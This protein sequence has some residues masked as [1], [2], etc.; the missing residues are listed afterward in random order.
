ME[1]DLRSLVLDVYDTQLG[2]WTPEHGELEI[3]EDWDFLIP[4]D[5]FVT[6]TVK[7]PASIGWRGCLGAA[8][9]LIVV[10]WACGPRRR[11][12]LR[13]GTRRRRQRSTGLGA[14]RPA[15]R[16]ASARRCAISSSWPT[17]WSP[18]WRSPPS[19]RRWRCGS[20]GSLPAGR[21]WWVAAESAEPGPC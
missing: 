2:W 6:R 8:T 11:P 5:A 3:P 10:D 13:R 1:P 18:S 15:R 21:R 7:G 20:R 12:S 4:G 16:P 19:I 14:A 17:R 9:D